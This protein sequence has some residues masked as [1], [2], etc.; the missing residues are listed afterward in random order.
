MSDVIDAI[1]EIAREQHGL[2]TLEELLH[3]TDELWVRRQVASE[4]LIRVAPRV[5]RLCGVRPTWDMRA[6]AAVLSARVPA[7]VSHRAAAALW[8]LTGD[9]LPGMID[10]TVPRHRRPRRRAGV[11]VHETLAFDLA[12]QEYRNRI[13]VTGVARTVLDCCAAVDDPEERLF[14]LDEARRKR[15]VTWDELWECLVLH[16]VRGRRSIPRFRQLLLERDGEVPPGSVFARRMGTL[17]T[18]AGLPEPVFEHPV[19]TA[20]RTYHLDLAWPDRMGGIE[21]HGGDHDGPRALE[22][23]PQR[24]NAIRMAG[25]FVLEYR[26]PYFV[27]HPA[28]VVDEVRQSLCA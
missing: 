20:V 18:D 10:I 25:W 17:L 2:I 27:H 5:F 12:G 4:R 3:F 23:D 6:M 28:A 15:L 8:G 24:L 13:P 7:L 26:W 16:D 21:C 14:L 22:R 9:V 19:D 11:A 1:D